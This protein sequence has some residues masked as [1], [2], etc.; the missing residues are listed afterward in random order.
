MKREKAFI[1]F[2]QELLEPLGQISMRRMF[3]GHGVYCNGLFIAIVVDGRPYLKVDAQS[4]PDCVAAGCTP[5]FYAGKN[6]PVEMSYWNVPE[7]ALDSA[8]DIEFRFRPI[9]EVMKLIWSGEMINSLHIASIPLA[10]ELYRKE[11]G[12]KVR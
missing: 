10:I 3:G 12:S 1:D 8:E 7:A 2:L 5:F 4:R 9:D 11:Q 6:N